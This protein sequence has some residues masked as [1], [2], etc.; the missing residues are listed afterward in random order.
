MI[1]LLLLLLLLLLTTTIIISFTIII[2]T[3]FVSTKFHFDETISL[4]GLVSLMSSF[5]IRPISMKTLQLY[6]F[7]NFGA[8][9]LGFGTVSSSK[10]CLQF[11]LLI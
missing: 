1:L 3:I 7:C 2:T 4:A 11:F 8:P 6:N 5:V 9:L 10:K